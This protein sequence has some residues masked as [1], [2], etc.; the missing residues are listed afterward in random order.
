MTSLAGCQPG[1]HSALFE[2]TYSRE[3]VLPHEA[4]RYRS[5]TFGRR[6]RD[7]LNVSSQSWGDLKGHR[8]VDDI[9]VYNKAFIFCVEVILGAIANLLASRYLNRI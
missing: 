7:L 3:N 6:S 4:N 8:T 9:T 2:M 5:C 1:R